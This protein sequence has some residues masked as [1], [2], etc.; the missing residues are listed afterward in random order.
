VD[1]AKNET[2]DEIDR[3]IASLTENQKMTLWGEIK[4]LSYARLSHPYLPKKWVS[5]HADRVIAGLVSR[6]LATDGAYPD[7]TD[8]G[9]QVAERMA[10][11]PEWKD[12]EAM[13]RRNGTLN[14]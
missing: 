12:W 8:L 10:E 9:R 7:L 5:M 3:L 11:D 4:G 14:S 2:G 1:L 13:C 6:K